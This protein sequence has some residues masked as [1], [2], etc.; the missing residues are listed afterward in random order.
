L[1]NLLYFIEEKISRAKNVEL[2]AELISSS[3][4]ILHVTDGMA[5]KTKDLKNDFKTCFTLME[6][7]IGQPRI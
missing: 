7:K 4:E 2:W 1:L 5:K 6:I 3:E